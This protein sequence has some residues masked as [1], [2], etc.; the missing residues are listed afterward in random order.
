M[1]TSAV[2]MLAVLNAGAALAHSSLVPHHHPHQG[3]LLPDMAA[4]A[5]AALL[6]AAGVAAFRRLRKE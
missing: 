5:L 6:V 1:K 3:S 2:A 4:L